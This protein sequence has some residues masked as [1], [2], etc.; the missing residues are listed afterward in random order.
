MQPVLQ[1]LF[2]QIAE[3]KNNSKYNENS[4]DYSLHLPG[5]HETFIN[6]IYKVH[7]ELYIHQLEK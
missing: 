5:T 6:F 1:H 2:S 3:V 4:A 7:T